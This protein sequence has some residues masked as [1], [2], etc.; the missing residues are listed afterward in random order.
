MDVFELI[1][2]FATKAILGTTENGMA[3]ALRFF[4]ADTIKV[5]ILLSVMVFLV[6]ILR[7]FIT[8]EKVKKWLGGR[9]EG[10]GNVLA[11]LLGVP[12]PFCSCS[13]VPL[14]MGFI[15]A[16]VPL[17]ITF[18]FLIS[19][20]MVNE[21]AVAMLLGL[22]GWKITA[23]YIATG[24]AVAITAGIIIGRLKM[25]KEVEKLTGKTCACKK[26]KNKTSWR[27]RIEFAKNETLRITTKTFP[28]ILLGIGI[29]AFVHGFVPVGFLAD[30]AGP[31]NP[32]AVPIAVL[33][34][35]PLYANA[36]AT[37]PIINALMAKG[38]A[39]GT[40]LALMMSIT[41]LSLP[42]M[43][44][45]RRVLKPKLL[46]VFAGTLAVAFVLTGLLFNAI[47]H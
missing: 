4:V 43:V 37:V 17:G 12:T 6:S 34:G 42:E 25:E 30:L 8:R 32:L 11:A 18:S 3:E 15:E 27:E 2:D 44:I 45:L 14:F 9:K 23:L 26:Q 1:G 36:A 20:P 47:L 16:G 38:M 28:Y 19:A 21:V 33:I 22:V 40:A 24:L 39:L 35:I 5:F 13:A 31:N 46:A 7:T 41:A 10:F 29:G